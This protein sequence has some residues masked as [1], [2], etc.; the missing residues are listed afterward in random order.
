MACLFNLNGRILK[1]RKRTSL[2]SILIQTCLRK[3]KWLVY[4][5]MHRFICFLFNWNVHGS[6]PEH[7]HSA[8]SCFISSFIIFRCCNSLSIDFTDSHQEEKKKRLYS[9]F[10]IWANPKIGSDWTSV[11][12]LTCMANP[13]GL[14]WDMTFGRAWVYAHALESLMKCHPKSVIWG[15]GKDMIW[16]KEGRIN[17]LRQ[18]INNVCSRSCLLSGPY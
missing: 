7:M 6:N 16:H 1:R 15:R 11:Q 13:H 2:S 9:F 17:I 10:I 14:G 18:K 12:L 3:N 4:L 8:S 5:C